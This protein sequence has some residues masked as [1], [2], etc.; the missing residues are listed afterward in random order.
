MNLKFFNFLLFLLVFAVTPLYAAADDE[1]AQRE[2]FVERWVEYAVL[3]LAA[4]NPE[5]ISETESRAQSYFTRQAY[6]RFFMSRAPQRFRNEVRMHDK[7]TAPELI[8]RPRVFA[9][10]I[11]N[12]HQYWEVELPVKMNVSTPK[13]DDYYLVTKYFVIKESYEPQNTSKI[14]IDAWLEYTFYEEILDECEELR[15][16]PV[17]KQPAG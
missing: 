13:K 11:K 15:F 3:D 9:T 7:S 6:E 8:C 10:Y 1:Q 12:G 5:T 14:A 4:L 2:D 16:T 17:L